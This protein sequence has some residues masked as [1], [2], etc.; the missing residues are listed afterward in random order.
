MVLK[1]L[2]NPVKIKRGREG[3]ITRVTFKKKNP[4]M[5]VVREHMEALSAYNYSPAP[6]SME[7]P[8]PPIMPKDEAAKLK[9]KEERMNL[10]LNEHGVS[11]IL[12]DLSSIPPADLKELDDA[13][14]SGEWNFELSMLG[15]YVLERKR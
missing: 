3:N 9:E 14:R 10:L 15:H 13:L 7:M 8:L 2:R 11:A 12:S 5:P 4:F 6:I 1:K